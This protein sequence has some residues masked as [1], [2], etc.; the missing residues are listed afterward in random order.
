MQEGPGVDLVT[1][2][3]TFITDELVDVIVCCEVFEHTGEWPQILETSY[4]NLNT[5]GILIGT[6]AGEGRAPHSAIDENPIRDWEY[7]ANV[8]ANELRTVLEANNFKNIII[9]NLNADIR[10]IAIKL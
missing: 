10:W 3:A 7:Y 5:N 8:K 4:K 6:A 1:N 2:A 9:N